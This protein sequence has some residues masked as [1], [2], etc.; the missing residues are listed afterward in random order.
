MSTFENDGGTDDGIVGS[1]A[2]HGKNGVLGRN[3]D[4]T[5]R[6]AVA[7][8]GN[9]IF[10]FTQVP[11][12]AGVFGLHNTGGMGVVGFGHPAGVGVVGMSVPA[13]AKGGDGVLGVSN[14]EHR[15]GIVGR[16]GS[17]TPRG[18]V[19]AGGNGVFGFTQVPD[20]AGVFGAHATS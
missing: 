8:E 14:S 18:S 2:A 3:D 20:G 15:N 13:D 16:N 19:D 4:T 5:A 9:G 7:P 11:D 10:G 1:T 6:N 17:T 12:G